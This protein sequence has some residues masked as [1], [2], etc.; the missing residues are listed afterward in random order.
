M[1]N[2]FEFPNQE[3]VDRIRAELRDYFGVDYSPNFISFSEKHGL[4]KSGPRI[5]NQK[6][7]NY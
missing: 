7:G 3:L 2:V 4:S 1:T 6:T 5:Q